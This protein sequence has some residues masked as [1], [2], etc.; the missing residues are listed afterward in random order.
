MEPEVL[1]KQFY[2]ISRIPRCSRNEE[3]ARRYVLKEAD[4]CGLPVRT[5]ETGNILVEKPAAPDR[6]KA[7]VVVVQSHLDMVCEKNRDST[8]DFAKDPLRLTEDQGWIKAEGT[9]LGADNGIGV[10]AALAIMEGGISRHGPVELLFTVDEETGLTGAEGLEGDFVQGRIL[11]NL[12]TEHEG[13]IFIGC[14]GGLFSDL[15][16]GLARELLP[17]GL[18]AA[19]VRVGGL[20]GG[21]SGLDIHQGR[22]NAIKLITRTLS[23]LASHMDIRVAAVDGGDKHNAIP[24]ECEAIICLPED[25][26]REMHRII[27]ACQQEYGEEYG[28]TDPGLFFRLEEKDLA[29]PDQVLSVSGQARLLNLL[30]CL[31]HGVLA[32]SKAVPGLVETSTNLAVVRTGKEGIL[33]QTKQRGSRESGLEEATAMV[34]AAGRL[35]GAEVQRSV[36]YPAWTPNPS[37][38]V[39]QIARK[40]YQGLYAKEP[41][42]MAVHAGLECAI[43]G[44]IFPGMDMISLGPTIEDAHSPDERMEIASVKKFWDFL[45]AL[46]E[47]I[48]TESQSP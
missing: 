18:R 26:F 2:E 46:L 47:R 3:E 6:E 9:T 36:R 4:R 29:L 24:R 32:M 33:I 28:H 17:Q 14:A 25:K 27:E 7:P 45:N 13:T 19:Q 35:A 41:E 37:S 23:R 8:H 48:S 21:H 34:A 10:A 11:L 38:P 1:W 15:E 43:L 5:D 22:G 42:V 20:K 31:P 30:C 40:T 12:D 39:L 16:L 44:S